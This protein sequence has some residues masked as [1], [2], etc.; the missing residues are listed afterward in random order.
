MPKKGVIG[1]IS[2]AGILVIAALALAFLDASFQAVSPLFG[3][4]WQ[5]VIFVGA[6]AYGAMTFGLLRGAS[7]GVRRAVKWIGLGLVL[8][9][10][11]SLFVFPALTQVPP[12][13]QAGAPAAQLTI[14]E[15]TVFNFPDFSTDGDGATGVSEIAINSEKLIVSLAVTATADANTL[16][17]DSFA[18]DFTLRCTEACTYVLD[19]ASQE[20]PYHARIV[21]LSDW[22]IEGNTTTIP[23]YEKNSDGTW[24]IAWT[25]TGSST[26]VGFADGGAMN[27]FS[28]GESGTFTFSMYF[29]ENGIPTGIPTGEV[30]TRTAIVQI[31]S[32]RGGTSFNVQVDLR[33]TANN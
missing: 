3:L 9:S 30:Y 24:M 16:V 29:N 26:I 17:P 14:A 19:G 2:L 21:G 6:A 23:I 4:S 12:G 20:T 15:G 27:L 13:G 1:G 7:A 10:V 18:I 28:T 25:D 11:G 32:P 22:V 31:F 33:L 5:M 8:F